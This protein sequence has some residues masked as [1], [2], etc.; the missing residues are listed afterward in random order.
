MCF[1]ASLFNPLIFAWISSA[2]ITNYAT[3][4]ALSVGEIFDMIALLPAPLLWILL[5][6]TAVYGKQTLFTVYPEVAKEAM[7]PPPR[8]IRRKEEQNYR[9]G[10]KAHFKSTM[11]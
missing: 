5:A 10:K 6:Y 9:R 8:D 2:V 11:S 3:L 1:I 7:M 4:R